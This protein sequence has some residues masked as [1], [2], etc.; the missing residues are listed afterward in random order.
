MTNQPSN[1]PTTTPPPASDC[2]PKCG[3][4]SEKHLFERYD[5]YSSKATHS[6]Y[7]EYNRPFHQ[8]PECALICR[9]RELTR[10]CDE[11]R[12]EN[13]RLA[14]PCPGDI[15]SQAAAWAS[16]YMMLEEIGINSFWCADGRSR[17]RAIEFVRDLQRRL[18]A[19]EADNAALIAAARDCETKESL[20]IALDKPHPGEPILTEL[21]KLRRDAKAA[22]EH[23]DM[24][25]ARLHPSYVKPSPH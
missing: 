16:L 15:K 23:I 2:C 4:M 17:V 12:A 18:E 10:E 1:V 7:V 13:E 5:C 14:N 9:V 22:E 21:V 11:L 3:A 6:H 25:F 19:A 8:S 24:G 20:A